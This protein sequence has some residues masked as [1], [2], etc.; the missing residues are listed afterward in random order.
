MQLPDSTSAGGA[1]EAVG[2]QDRHPVVNVPHD[3]ELPFS[4]SDIGAGAVP[5]HVQKS[6]LQWLLAKEPQAHFLVLQD[7]LHGDQSMARLLLLCQLGHT[8]KDHKV[9]LAEAGDHLTSGFAYLTVVVLWKG[10][11]LFA[12]FFRLKVV[13]VAAAASIYKTLARFEGAAVCPARLV[14]LTGTL[15]AWEAARRRQL[16]ST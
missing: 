8:P 7:L 1:H 4:N 6:H 2:L 15:Q 9:T 13:L 3:D 12:G 16:S 5:V 10:A 14:R 11:H